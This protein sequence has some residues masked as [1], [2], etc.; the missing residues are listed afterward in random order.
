MAAKPDGESQAQSFYSKQKQK[1]R[2]N[3]SNPSKLP[4]PNQHAPC[5][6]QFR[7][8]NLACMNHPRVNP[9]SGL[10]CKL[11]I[12]QPVKEANP[13]RR[14]WPVT[15]STS[16]PASP[17]SPGKKGFPNILSSIPLVIWLYPTVMFP[18]HCPRLALPGLTIDSSQQQ[19][20]PPW[21]QYKA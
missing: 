21:L 10:M 9:Y 19:S 2:S 17:V 13:G 8:L 6:C 18:R 20:A 4:G 15:P 3:H 1:Q 16:D 11:C 14:S 7:C 12:F 5:S